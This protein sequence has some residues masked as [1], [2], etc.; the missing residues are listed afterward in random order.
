MVISLDTVNTMSS[1][2]VCHAC[3]SL[4]REHFCQ[5][6]DAPA[7]DAQCSEVNPEY[8]ELLRTQ[9]DD[10][11]AVVDEPVAWLNVAIGSV[12][13]SPVVVMDWDDEKEPVQSLYRHP[14]RP[15]VMPERIVV[16]RGDFQ[17][18]ERAEALKWNACL[19]EFERLNPQ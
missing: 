5:I 12:T 7:E 16:P 15:I 13:T 3:V 8:S 1:R 6:C 11:P 17:P 2:K 9:A 4:S 10:V 18:F 19:D 14:P